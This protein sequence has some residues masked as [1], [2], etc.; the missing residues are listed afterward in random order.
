MNGG[1]IAS[2]VDIGAV[3]TNWSV[4]KPQVAAV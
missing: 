4:Q 3:G 2:V 1:T